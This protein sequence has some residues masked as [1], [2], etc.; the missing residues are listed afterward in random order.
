MHW[1]TPAMTYAIAIQRPAR[2]SQRTLPIVRSGPWWPGATATGARVE[3]AASGDGS[4][5]T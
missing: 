5:I 1:T 4:D 2:T 3:G